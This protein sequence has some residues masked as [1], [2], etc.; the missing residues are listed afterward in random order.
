[1]QE[2][3]V[4]PHRADVKAIR[5]VIEFQR[6]PIDPA[7]IQERESFYRRMAWV[8]DSTKFFFSSLDKDESPLPNGMYRWLWMRKSWLTASMPIFFDDGGCDLLQ[9]TRFGIDGCFSFV[10]ITKRAFIE[11]WT[12][13]LD[14][15]RLLPQWHH[16]LYSYLRNRP[17]LYPRWDLGPNHAI[18][19]QDV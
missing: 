7:T 5:G 3:V 1:M 2:V 4:G 11:Q 16:P 15:Q 9:V 18:W 12:G 6:S 13:L 14:H 17:T 19:G 8:V 10:R